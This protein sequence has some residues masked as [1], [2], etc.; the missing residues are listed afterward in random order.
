MDWSSVLIWWFLA[1]LFG[2]L[3]LPLA[4]RLFRRLPDRGYGV[5]KALGLL[6]TGHVFWLLGVLGFL[7]NDAGGMIFSMALVAAFSLALYFW[8]RE[9]AGQPWFDWLKD[10]YRLVL[11]T[12]LVFTVAFVAWA[13][14]RANVPNI[15]TAGGEKFMEIAF[16]N[17]IERSDRLPP[18]D[19]WLSGYVISYYYFGYVIVSMLIQLSQVATSV[20]FN[21]GVALLFA[22]TAAGAFSLVYNLV[23]AIDQQRTTNGGEDQPPLALRLGSNH[24]RHIIAALLGIVFVLFLSNLEAPLDVLHHNGVGS[25]AVWRWLDIPE[26]DEP[27]AERVNWDWS[28]NRFR[29]WWRASRIVSDY[30][31]CDWEHRGDQSGDCLPIDRRT[32]IDEFPFFSFLLGDMHPHVLGLPFVLLALTCSWALLQAGREVAGKSQGGRPGRGENGWLYRSW[33]EIEE[34][35]G[36]A[37]WELFV[38]A[39]VLGALF[40][41]NAWDFPFQWAV[42]VGAYALGRLYSFLH[43]RRFHL[44]PVAV[45]GLTLGGVGVLLFFPFYVGFQSQAA[46]WPPLLIHIHS[47]TRL[48]H[49]GVMFGPLLFVLLSFLAWRA[50]RARSEG[51]LALRFG[52]EVGAG[53]LLFASFVLLA[54]AMA[55]W[56]APDQK[57]GL[58][59][60]N[61]LISLIA[62]GLENEPL[63]QVAL[64]FLAMRLG[65]PWVTLLL[66]GMVAVAL[67]LLRSA[68]PQGTQ[69]PLY[70][71]ILLLIIAGAVVAL[72]PDY[73]Y[74]KDIFRVRLNTVFKFY[75]QTWVM[76]AVAATCAT[77]ALLT[78]E[79]R[80]GALGGGF[81][82]IGLVFVFTC[83]LIYPA[84]AIPTRTG[85]FA[86]A[87]TL[88]GTAYLARQQ[89][90]DYAAI[91]WLD[92]NVQGSAV[93]LEVHYRGAYDYRGRVSALTG[94]PTLLGWG[95]HEHQWRGSGE[96][97][98]R[99]A[100]VVD[101]LYTTRN[102]ERFLT[103]LREYDITYIYVGPLESQTFDLIEPTELDRL[104]HL[105][106]KLLDLVYDRDGVKIYQ[107]VGRQ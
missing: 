50:W 6:L 57:L 42:A 101:E 56:L 34:D 23:A 88:D 68:G 28:P 38:F 86:E 87:P 46:G 107:V 5:S 75:F 90:A 94:L 9:Q 91:N 33:G 63:G 84:L 22:L 80:P 98:D 45:L 65:A 51:R 41:L 85:E 44:R 61:R 81:F 30:D 54:V 7:R 77:Y 58:F 32:N 1:E 35:L 43:S 62:P 55:L 16:L 66:I 83:G 24:S 10:H 36:L 71:F 25:A 95:S 103:L 82:A 20:G 70:R 74:I 47:S 48:T 67:A 15:E 102:P 12:E 37:G 29:W 8:R 99:R 4:Y 18:L 72:I 31:L 26:I 60:E 3:T 2:W 64:R 39:L 27:P 89:P 13:I 106:N 49:F 79:D 93:I 92:E 19:P 21:L 53:I 73:F 17:A 59:G 78:A 40:F 96:L 97:P 100:R 104:T 11:V 105:P 69:R 14:Y 76:W 52:L